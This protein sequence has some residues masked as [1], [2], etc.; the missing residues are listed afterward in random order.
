MNYVGKVFSTFKGLYNDINPATLTGAIDVIIVRQE[1]GTYLSSPWHVRFGKIGVMRAKQKVVDIEVNG[2]PVDLHMKLGEAGEAFFVQEN[3]D[4]VEMPGYLATSPLLSSMELMESGIQQMKRESGAES[5][6]PHSVADL[7]VDMS[8]SPDASPG[9]TSSPTVEHFEPIVSMKENNKL[10]VSSNN[11]SSP[12]ELATTLISCQS[13]SIS[14]MSTTHTTPTKQT[15]STQTEMTAC[16]KSHSNGLKSSA[17]ATCL[18]NSCDTSSA[19]VQEH[20]VTFHMRKSSVVFQDKILVPSQ[21]VM[22]MRRHRR[23]KSR[24]IRPDDY[25]ASG[26]TLSSGRLE[27]KSQASSEA[28]EGLFELELGKDDAECAAIKRSMELS[29]IDRSFSLSRICE[30]DP[31]LPT[32]WTQRQISASFHSFSDAEFTP[33]ASP[34]DSRPTSPMS[35]TEVTLNNSDA[36]SQTNLTGDRLVQVDDISWKWGKIPEIDVSVKEDS[37]SKHTST[38]NTN[39]VSDLISSPNKK[40][41]VK[42]NEGMYLDDIKQDEMDPELAAL[43]LYG[44]H[45]SHDQATK[46]IQD[47]DAESGNGQSLPQSP[48][49]VENEP[50]LISNGSSP[51]SVKTTSSLGDV[52][53]SLCGGLEERESRGMADKFESHRVTYE[54]LCANPNILNDPN[55][56]VRI[57]NQ[58]YNWAIAGPMFL[59]DTVFK[60]PL[61]EEQ[62]ALTALVK[63]HMPKKIQKEPSKRSWYGWGWRNSRKEANDSSTATTKDVGTSPPSSRPSI[64]PRVGDLQRSDVKYADLLSSDDES[65]IPTV[66]IHRPSVVADPALDESGLIKSEYMKSLKLSSEQI[67]KLR[68]NDGI[69]EASFS[70]TTQYQGTAR[71]TCYVFLWN[72][73]DKI[74]IS[75]IDGTI[76]K[77]DVLGQVLPIIGQ[78]LPLI[79]NDWSQVGIANLYSMIHSNGYRFLYLSARA[80]GQSRLT[81]DYL[82][83][84]R[85]GVLS[86]PEGPLLLSPSSLASAFHREVIERKPEVFK[87]SCLSDI[88]Q[89]F[90]SSHNPFF[91]GFGNKINDVWAYRA[92]GVPQDRIFTVNYHGQLRIETLLCYQSS[93]SCLSDI[94]DHFFPPLPNT[95]TQPGG[96]FPCVE[97]NSFMYWRE[98]LPTLDDEISEFVRKNEEEKARE[99]KEAKEKKKSSVKKSNS[100]AVVTTKK[101]SVKR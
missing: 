54:A 27:V 5:N 73:N 82:R 39:K 99:A 15:V 1:D 12:T 55:L 58:Y 6:A 4:T 52:E 53:I 91:G 19:T 22:M 2:E 10:I 64:S 30:A 63:Q 3:Q 47:E 94:V 8:S 24:P 65:E 89:L 75:D 18:H 7:P 51:S 95:A 98:P 42:A 70:V 60:Q 32:A 78:V 38:P 35:D 33:L 96:K 26:T 62:T 93:Y 92:V 23:K 44:H 56:V 77:S 88:K 66:T 46:R 69:N 41:A 72:W 34:I 17:S 14:Y 37:S 81:R 11:S 48:V 31:R 13:D 76:T 29:T 85:Q 100:V 68:L 83:S 57:S 86:L 71:C 67:A 97:Y 25:V 80:I 36:M 79:S 49:T 45:S 20:D 50:G 40:D 84:L 28:E 101:A 9:R 90:P 59:S 16:K 61:T 74:V 21:D 43:Y 87:I